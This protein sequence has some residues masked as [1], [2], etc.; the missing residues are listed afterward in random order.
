MNID[1]CWMN[2]PKNKDPKRVGFLRDEKGNVNPNSYFSDMKGLIDYIHSKGLKAGIYT[3]PG[4]LTC[5]GFTGAFHH[6]AQDARQFADWG[7][8]FLKYDWCSYGD[9]ATNG[10][11][12]DTTIPHW[13]KGSPTLEAYQ[14][15]YRKM[16]KILQQQNRDIV[17]NLCQYGM[18]DV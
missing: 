2:A 9:I 11:K 18:G 3:S 1:D 13:G 15:P 14:Y 10:I 5:G 8:D 7:F 17:Y 12:D 6:E 16:G 4:T